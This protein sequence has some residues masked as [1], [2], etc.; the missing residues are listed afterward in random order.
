MRRADL[1]PGPQDTGA[2]MNRYVAMGTSVSMGVASDGVAFD[3]NTLLTSPTPIGPLISL[4]GV[5]PSAAGQAVLASAA[6]AAII[7]TYGDIS[8]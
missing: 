3:L 5:H 2:N 8:P 6:R 1:S 4:D 7:Q